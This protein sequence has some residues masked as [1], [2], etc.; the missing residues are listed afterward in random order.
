MLVDDLTRIY[1]QEQSSQAKQPAYR[2]E[3][4]TNLT[5][6]QIQVFEA[7]KDLGAGKGKDIAKHLGE[8][9]QPALVL[10]VLINKG[11]VSVDENRVYYTSKGALQRYLQN[12]AKSSKLIRCQQ[13]AKRS[14]TFH[15]SELEHITNKPS[16]LVHRMYKRGLVKNVRPGVWEWLNVRSDKQAMI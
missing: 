2:K 15:I 7:V 9:S 3:Y 8:K 14:G 12:R 13:Y 1:E 11:H 5:K 6:R 16:N 4:K 10:N